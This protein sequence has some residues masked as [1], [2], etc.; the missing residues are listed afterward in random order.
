MLNLER[1]LTAQAWIII[2]IKLIINEIE[3]AFNFVTCSRPGG[4]LCKF[5]VFLFSSNWITNANGASLIVLK[6]E[7]IF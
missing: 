1:V 6:L 5:P 4:G 7:K 3:I 2:I